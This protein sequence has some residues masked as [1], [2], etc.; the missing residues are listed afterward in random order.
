[1]LSISAGPDLG[2]VRPQATVIP[3]GAPNASYPNYIN[4]FIKML[5]NAFRCIIILQP[6]LFMFINLGAP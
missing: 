2:L 4:N 5:L 6:F 3:P 1:V